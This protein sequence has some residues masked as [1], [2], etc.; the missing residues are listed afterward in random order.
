MNKKQLIE[1]LSDP[2]Y[3]D[4]MEVLIITNL[5]VLRYIEHVCISK[6]D[7]YEYYKSLPERFIEMKAIQL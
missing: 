2:V 7:N 4:N 6:V 3:P 1:I 5:G